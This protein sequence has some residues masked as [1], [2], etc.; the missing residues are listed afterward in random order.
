MPSIHLVAIVSILD[1]ALS[2]YISDK[3][4]PWPEKT[5]QDLCNRINVVSEVI[6]ELDPVPLHK[7]RELRNKSAHPKNI[8]D[9]QAVNWDSLNSAIDAVINA[10]L[11]IGQIDNVPKIEASYSREPIFYPEDLGPN[12]ERMIH[13]HKIFAKLNNIGILEYAQEVSYFP[14]DNPASS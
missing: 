3:N 6:K 9:C 8:Q 11:V 1:E 12:G 2:N 13:K 10:F 7:I 14:P 4:I 5:K